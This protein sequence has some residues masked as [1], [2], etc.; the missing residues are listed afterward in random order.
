MR[1]KKGRKKCEKGEKSDGKK[2]GQDAVIL[3]AYKATLKAT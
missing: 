2:D 1:R 3:E